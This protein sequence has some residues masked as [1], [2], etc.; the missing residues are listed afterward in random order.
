MI[1]HPAGRLRWIVAGLFLVSTTPPAWAAKDP[2]PRPRRV[3]IHVHSTVST[4]ELAPEQILPLAEEA[5]L[6]AV[7]FTD[8]TLRRWEYGLRPLQGLLRKVV[9]QPSVMTFGVRR[10][11]DLLTKLSTPELMVLPGTEA[12][13]AYYWS[14]N[15]FDKRG[16]QIR[17][18]SQHV[19]ILGLDD[20]KD[21]EALR[22]DQVD[23]YHGNPGPTPYQRVID[24]VNARGGLVFWAHPQ[25][26]HQ[27][28]QDGI[29][30]YTDPYPHLLEQTSGY[31]GFAITYWDQFD[32]VQPGGLW[33]RVLTAYCQ[34]R[35]AQPVWVIGE[36]DWRTPKERPLDQLLTIVQA[37]ART[38]QALLKAMREGRMWAVFRQGPQ[39]PSLEKFEIVDQHGRSTGSGGWAAS[40][41]L[42]VVIQGHRG[43]GA[44]RAANMFL[45]RNGE[46]FYAQ[47]V[48]QDDFAFSWVDPAPPPKG[49]YRAIYEGPAG[50][51]YTNPI[52]VGTP[53]AKR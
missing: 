32:L 20:P 52:F 26:G 24:A 35:R 31:H 12:A 37:D 16:G 23:P 28:R 43:E 13:P 38:P 7:I 45:V 5:G 10:Y 41:P 17:G 49:Y 3:G 42:R 44:G 30:D 6:D 39:A 19:L 4:G 29:E 33:D 36:L 53:P 11:V 21:F 1:P 48:A 14:R 50:R 18:W 34:G 2:P 8:T 47:P 40:G 25:M 15:P 27:G 9:E 22:L 51:I 46:I